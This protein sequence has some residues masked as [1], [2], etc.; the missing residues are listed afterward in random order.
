MTAE[1]FFKPA[2]T[3]YYYFVKTLS[4]DGAKKTKEKLK[5]CKS[6]R[7]RPVDQFL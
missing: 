4:N 6:D 2:A 1:A 7:Y 3:I 5:L